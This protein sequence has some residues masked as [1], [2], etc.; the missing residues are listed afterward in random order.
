[1]PPEVRVKIG[2]KIPETAIFD[3]VDPVG[4]AGICIGPMGNI[5]AHHAY[6]EKCFLR[7]REFSSEAE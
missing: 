5:P 6:A 2:L 7:I 4:I 3:H 1:M